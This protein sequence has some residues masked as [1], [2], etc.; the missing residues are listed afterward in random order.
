MKKLILCIIFFSLIASCVT[1]V[2]RPKLT[3]TIVDEEGKPLDS[4]LVR[5]VYTDDHGNYELPEITSKRLFSFYGGLP[6]FISER[7]HKEG[8]EPKELVG[9]N[10]RG[11]ISVGSVWNMDTI[12]LRKALTDFSKVNVHAHWHASMTKNLDT[13]FMTKKD[14]EYDPTKV[15]FIAR[16][17]DTYARGYYFFGID[18]LPENVFERHIAVTLADSTLNIQRVLIYGD[19]KTSEKTKYDTIYAQ[20]KWKQV[21]KILSFETDLPELNGSYKV[22]DFNHDSMELIKQ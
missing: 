13:V 7:I 4:C 10:S 14:L 15:D 17:H 2:L 11:G 6:I 20:G 9:G 19:V 18:N 21:H 5:D 12:R 8:Y 22:V 16:R 1:Q 3:G